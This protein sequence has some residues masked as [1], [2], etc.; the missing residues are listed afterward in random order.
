MSNPF[1]KLLASPLDS[2]RRDGVG[3]VGAD[4]PPELLLA[5][6]RPFGHLPWY[7]DAPTPAADRW[8]EPG[9]PGWARSIL[10]Q[11][12]AGAFDGIAD[13]VFS[14]ADD[15]AQRLCYYVRE[16]QSRGQLRG[17]RPHLL[18]L[19]LIPRESSLRHTAR[20]IEAL[21]AR[22]GV[23]PSAWSSA[24]ARA[25]VLRLTVAAMNSRRRSH[26][27]VFERIFRAALWSDATQWIADVAVPME[28]AGRRVLLAGSM[29]P[30][31]R[32]HRA[33]EAGGACIVDEVHFGGPLRLGPA[34]GE[35][36][37]APALRIARHLQQHGTGPRVFADRAAQLI[38]RVRECGAQGVILWMTREDEAL[39]WQ[40]PAQVKALEEAGVPTLVLADRRWAADDGALESITRFCKEKFA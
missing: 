5:S 27:P 25:D 22:L 33:A 4:I 20:S 19:A 16:L 32:L 1:E 29:P 38:A 21:A 18:D 40:V 17:P 15:A 39:A 6:G 13:V 2:L 36:P 37:E 31:D 26:G 10:E 23:A 9:F 3:F 11:W 14:R 7:T 8:L 24:I 35:S 34:L 30:D 28:D 12:F